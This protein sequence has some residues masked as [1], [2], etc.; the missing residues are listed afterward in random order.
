MRKFCG[1]V[2]FRVVFYDFQRSSLSF[3]PQSIPPRSRTWKPKCMG[4]NCGV[5]NRLVDLEWVAISNKCSIA[6]VHCTCRSTV[7]VLYSTRGRSGKGVVLREQGE[8]E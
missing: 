1:L 4:S 7:L 3:V 2:F 6:A 8:R 5:D